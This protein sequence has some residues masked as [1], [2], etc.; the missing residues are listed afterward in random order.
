MM[1]LKPYKI[2][3]SD[4]PEYDAD[5]K[6]P[7]NPLREELEVELREI[8]LEITDLGY[9][10]SLSG[11]TRGFSKFQTNTPYV[12]IRNVRTFPFKKGI[13]HDEFW[14]E[15]TDTVERIKDYLTGKGFEVSQ[16]ILNEGTSHEQVY[17]Y[18]DMI[19]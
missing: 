18:F 19:N 5:W 1:Y 3:E 17:I 4:K 13:S 10:P 12:W 15:I 14:N 8:L 7:G 11:F 6:R 2:F 16:N 9:R